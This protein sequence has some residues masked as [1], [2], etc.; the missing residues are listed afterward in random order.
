MTHPGTALGIS[1]TIMLLTSSALFA[2]AAEEGALIEA[3][4]LGSALQAVAEEYDLQLLYESA[5]VTNLSAQAVPR[6]ASSESALNE[7]LEGTNLSYQFVN[8]RTVT[9]QEK[10][11]P[12]GQEPGKSQPASM[13]T[14]IAQAGTP[15][16][17]SQMTGTAVTNSGTEELKGLVIEEIVVTARKREEN[18]QDVPISISAFS[19][20][21]M[22]ARSL[23]SLQE[24]GQFTP[25]FSFY[26]HAQTGATGATVFIRGVGQ[27]DVSIISDP[28]VGVYRDGIYMGRMQG[29][30]FDLMEI[31]RVEI[32]RGPQGTL[33]GKNTI[34]GSVNVVT[35]RPT[36]EFGGNVSIT[37]GRFDRFDVKASVNVPLVPGKLTA[38]FAG[39]TRNRDGY[40]KRLDFA[41]GNMIDETGDTDRSTGRAIFNWIPTKNVDVLLS[42][43]GTRV[44]EAGPVRKVVAF[45]QPGIIKLVNNFV[46]PDYGDAF[47]TDSEFTTFATEGNANELDTWG[48]D[49]TVEWDFGDWAV[50]SITSYRDMEALGQ[51][52]ADGSNY[53]IVSNSAI[54]EQDQFSQE[55]QVSGLS[56]DDR[57][58]WVAGLYYLKETGF[59]DTPAEVLVVLRDII[60]LDASLERNFWVDTKNYAAFGQGTYALTDK[61]N[62]TA[63]LRYT[64]EE[65]NV[66]RTRFGQFSGKVVVPLASRSDNW[67][68]VSGRAGFE[69]HWNSDVMTYA[70]VARGFKSGGFNARSIGDSDFLSYDPEYITTY[71]AGLRSDLLDQH[72]RFN[73][74]V[75]YSDYE[76]IQFTVSRPDP[77]SLLPITIIGNVT[78]ARVKGFEVDIVATP[79]KGL[80]FNASIGYTDAE[81]TNVD[82]TSP[83]TEDTEF[84]KTPKWTVTTSGQYVMSLETWGEL[85][86]RL[87]YAY[88]TKTHHD[89][90][91]SPFNVQKSYG[92]L[93][94]RLTFISA[95]GN[96]E[97]SV[98]GT[99]LTDKRYILAGF[100]LLNALGFATVQYARPREWGVSF[101]YSF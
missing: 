48:A 69:Y 50:K 27:A 94:G 32:L 63:G 13:Q 96:W 22:E 87:D 35:S 64:Y 51:N 1:V 88:K 25:N 49:L 30:D 41:T 74:T 19:A 61:L 42:I 3:Q 53:G 4:A 29:I 76:D 60:G 93:N 7:L 95:T 70:S 12:K 57:L 33:F 43:D 46:D 40:G 17:Q 100:D 55:L 99:N 26:N 28:G 38:K 79:T 14:L 44:R 65:K 36:N 84:V 52:D 24:L 62:L 20:A 101:K 10:E 9:I 5:L 75:F 97:V 77:V 78:K 71:E 56:F 98:F 81:Y 8:E 34:G 89:I 31:E 72:L 82:P 45:S 6:G 58:T 59:E 83:I 66:A 92:L 11:S 85:I 91:N 21:D 86:G 23:T 80:T 54:F 67:D 47:L 68:A 90:E 16:Q 15:A 73:T 18:I 39:V 2:Q 37:T